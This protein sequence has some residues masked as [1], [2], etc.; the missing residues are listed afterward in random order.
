MKRLCFLFLFLLLLSSGCSSQPDTASEPISVDN[1]FTLPQ[2]P[3]EPIPPPTISSGTATY[4]RIEN[5]VT[6]DELG[7][8]LT[9]EGGEMRLCLRMRADELGEKDFGIHLYV[10]GQPQPYRIEADKTQQYMHTFPSCN[11]KEFTLVLIFTPLTGRTGDM[12]EIGFA[13]IAYPDYFIDDVWEGTTT[14]DWNCMGMTVRM[15]YQA[16]PPP[17]CLPELPDRL[18]QLSLEYTDLTSAETDMFSSDTYLKEVEYEFRANQKKDFGSFFSVMPG[19]N[20]EFE[21]ELKGSSLADFGLVLYL[22]HQPVSVSEEEL[23][24]V[25]TENGQKVTVR[26]QIDLA[27]FDGE[28]VFYAVLVPRNYR[29]DDLG[30]SCLLTILGPYYLS[31]AESLEAIR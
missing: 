29:R 5:E 7:P 28:D 14:I 20:L 27:G 31:G 4:I 12:L 8:Y 22:D 26:V 11:G 6:T 17:V 18:K 16:D 15:H 2:A 19:D 25:R 13:V 30:G 21:F 23:I 10:D 24:L 3:T 9:Y 1:I